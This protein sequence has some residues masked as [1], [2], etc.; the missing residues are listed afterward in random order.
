MLIIGV[1]PG[2]EQSAWLRWQY[3]EEEILDMEICRSEDLASRIGQY[4]FD[5]LSVEHF[6]CM[7][8]MVSRSVFDTCYWIGELR[9]WAKAWSTKWFPVFRKDIKMH[10]CE[11]NRVKDK[12]IRRALIDRFGEPGTKKAKGRLY[13]VKK[14]LWSALAIAVYTA[15]TLG[16]N[17]GG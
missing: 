12:N 17:Y 4:P 13:G 9:S 15:D 11:D 2:P 10:F 16:G 7:G 5:V 14:D 8:Q 3:P 1:D 6:A